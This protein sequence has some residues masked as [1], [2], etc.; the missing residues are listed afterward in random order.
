MDNIEE[1]AHDLLPEN[2]C[3]KQPYSQL[4]VLHKWCSTDVFKDNNKYA[5]LQLTSETDW[6]MAAQTG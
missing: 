4:K 3:S 5:G 6:P 1:D 2:Q